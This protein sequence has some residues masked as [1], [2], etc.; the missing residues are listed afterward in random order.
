M[1][2]NL[3]QKEYNLA[4]RRRKSAKGCLKKLNTI[5][6]KSSKRDNERLFD[7]VNNLWWEIASKIKY[8]GDFLDNI[9]KR[10]EQWDTPFEK[11]RKAGEIYDVTPIARYIC[12]TA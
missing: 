6:Q 5:V 12:P 4:Y 3:K 2:N 11:K 1:S 9:P 7:S 10:G 8:Y